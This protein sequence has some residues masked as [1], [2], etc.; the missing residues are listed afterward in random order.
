MK[1][2]FASLPEHLL[3]P[4][5]KEECQLI[6]D[7]LNRFLEATGLDPDAFPNL[8]RFMRHT[9][10]YRAY[11]EHAAEGGWSCAGLNLFIEDRYYAAV[12]GFLL[13]G[14]RIA[15]DHKIR[16]NPINKE[17]LLEDL[18]DGGFRGLHANMGLIHNQESVALTLDFSRKIFAM[19]KKQD[20]G[21]FVVSELDDGASAKAVCLMNALGLKVCKFEFSAADLQALT[22][23]DPQ[24][25]SMDSLVGTSNV[26]DKVRQP[27]FTDDYSMLRTLNSICRSASRVNTKEAG[28]IG[29]VEDVAGLLPGLLEVP[30]LLNMRDNLPADLIWHD[31][32]GRSDLLCGFLF[33]LNANNYFSTL[34]ALGVI[35]EHEWFFGVEFP[36]Q[37][38]LEQQ[39]KKLKALWRVAS[40][41]LRQQINAAAT[42]VEDL[43]FVELYDAETK[44]ASQRK[45]MKRLMEGCAKQH[46]ADLRKTEKYWPSTVPEHLWP[47]LLSDESSIRASSSS[48]LV[49]SFLIASLWAA[50]SAR[51]MN[52]GGIGLPFYP[53]HQQM[54]AI[55][56][57]LKLPMCEETEFRRRTLGYL[58]EHGSLT[59]EVMSM[60]GWGGDVLASLGFDAPG[61]VQAAMLRNDLGL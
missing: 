5:F 36:D 51:T 60:L 48:V 8:A 18:I 31:V 2:L 45:V 50:E 22:S 23:L 21:H 24:I 16:G 20:L 7:G 46:K 49:S 58:H 19:W 53:K 17:Q 34:I 44:S 14:G 39:E 12:A 57:T 11:I 26:F 29:A 1:T 25:F 32:K 28:L 41:A 42:C 30:L 33:E 47:V 40:P 61:A 13:D 43:A 54:S 37:S 55:F 27:S 9:E 15:D 6:L 38:L 4:D 3:A 56:R 10:L 59:D 35:R 52:V